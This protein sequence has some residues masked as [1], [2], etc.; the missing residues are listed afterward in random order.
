MRRFFTYFCFV[1]I[2]VIFLEMAAFADADAAAPADQ[3]FAEL[4]ANYPLAARFMKG[5]HVA[6]VFGQAFGSGSSAEETARQFINEYAPVFGAL[7][8]D[9]YPVNYLPDGR[10]TLPL[11]YDRSVGEY[12]FALVYYSQLKS[13]IP[14]FRADLRLLVKNESGYP[15]VLASSGLRSLGDYSVSGVPVADPLLAEQ[16]VKSFHPGLVNFGEPRLVIWA[17]LEDMIAEP[18]LAMEITADNGKMAAPDYDKWLF[19]IDV[20]SGE[21]LYSENMI[22][23]VD[24]IGN[25][26][27]MATQ[28][29]RADFCDEEASFPLPY[30]RVYID[31]GQ[32]VFADENGD[33]VIPNSGNSPVTVRSHLRGQWFRVY[34]Q[35]GGNSELALQVT[36]PGPANFLHN[37]INDDQFNRAEVNGYRHSNVIRDFALYYYPTYPVIWQQQEFA[38]NVNINETCNAYYD[39]YSIN[40]F[41]SG[42]GCSNTA[43]STVVHHEY[44]HHLV[45]VGG[46]QQGAYGEGM[47]DVVGMLVTDDPGLAYGFFNN[48]NQYMRTGDNDFQ[49]PCSGEIHYCGQLLSGCVWSTRNAL[50][51]TYPDSYLDIISSLAINTIPLHRGSDI[52]PDITL[53]YLTIDDDDNNIWNGTPHGAEIIQGFVFEHNMDFGVSPQIEHT[54]LLDNEDSTAALIVRANVYSFFSMENGSV[55]TFY[56][57]GGEFQ[58]L[59]MVNTSGDIWEAQIPSPPYGTA[60]NYYIRATDE[61]GIT[62]YSPPGAP[63]SVY[64]FFFGADIIS[65]S[66]TLV[67]FPPNTVNLFGPYGPFIITAWDIH[68]VDESDVKLHYRVNNEN[69]NV[70]Y[71]SL[72]GNENEFAL[73][74]IDLGRQLNPG[75]IVNCYF[76]AFDQ[77]NTP[78]LGRLP[79]T[80]DFELLM[81]NSEVFEDFEEFGIDRWALEGEWAWREPG[82]NGGHA[83]TYGPGYPNNSNDLAY[84]DFDYDLSPYDEARISLYHRNALLGGDSCFILISNN[85]GS[86]WATVG[87]I[88]GYPGNS[89]I[90]DVYDISSVLDPEHHDYRIGFRFISDPNTSAGILKIDDIGWVVGPMT[91]VDESRVSLPDQLS[92]GQNY[93]NPFNPQTNIYFQLPSKSAVSLDVFDVLGRRIATLI[94]R[95]MDAGGYTITWNGI[96]SAGRPASSGIY[97]YRLSTDFG[98]KQAK[99]TLLK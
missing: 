95:V 26:A 18:A 98:S 83:L 97:F 84:M 39:G 15:L 55:S 36:P 11:M 91:G 93:P 20:H 63:D 74:Q 38:V 54:P 52:S 81:A 24:V 82:Y 8:E 40:F 59:A 16:A 78:N 44:G 72:T 57:V 32:P 35:G 62:S 6:R 53:D 75:D 42:G 49:Y 92:L 48:C 86:T 22:V 60:V 90:Y 23:E 77:A 5:D 33:F 65:P 34:N 69:E 61:M 80:G 27:G 45:N 66:M 29:N 1:C 51:E 4:K 41:R 64:S 9:L 71:L 46:S 19:V 43:F 68:G 10:Q 99:M 94:D 96:D 31:G 7:P 3:A 67:D 89:F 73:D 17:G 14:V 70:A 28:G 56:S 37:E 58:S 87:S 25:V 21:I 79:Q 12:K 2:P 85:G 47:G 50:L 13:G 30:A 76:T 88:S